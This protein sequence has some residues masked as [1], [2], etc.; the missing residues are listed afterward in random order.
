MAPECKNYPHS[1]KRQVFLYETDAFGHLNNVFY[2]QYLESA[3]FEM[4]KE[5]KL[6]D[7][8]DIFSLNY[9][10]VHA[11]CDYRQISRYDDTLIIHSR[12]SD[13][14][15]SSFTLEHLITNEKTGNLVATAKMII[16]AFNHKKQKSEPL[17]PKVKKILE[18][19][20]GQ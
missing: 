20:W 16:V 7:P 6:F 8:G 1:Y 14:K 19:Y 2:F 9:I 15:K 12:V 4:L 5:M 13:I 17:T 3:R 18:G 11:E 10:L